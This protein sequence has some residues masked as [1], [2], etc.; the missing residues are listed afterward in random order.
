MQKTMFLPLSP[1]M[2]DESTNANNLQIIDNH[3]SKQFELH[4]D[5]PMFGTHLRLM[6]GDLKTVNR[7][8]SIKIMRAL[9]SAHPYDSLNWIMVGLGLWHLRLNL[10]RLIHKIHWEGS[11][12]GDL[13]SLQY[14]ADRWGRSNLSQATTADFRALEDL[15]THS[16]YARITALLHKTMGKMSTVNMKDQK[17]HLEWIASHTKPMWREQLEKIHEAIHEGSTPE[18]DDHPD[19]HWL[20][21]KRFCQHVETYLLLAYA[22]KRADIG[23][24]RRALRECCI[25][26]QSKAGGKW[27][28]GRELI[29]LIHLVDSP[30]AHPDLQ[31]AVLVNSLTNLHT[32][33]KNENETFET[34]RLL[35]LLNNTLK[36]FRKER[37]SSTQESEELLEMCALNGPFF[38]KLKRGIEDEFGHPTSQAHPS[39]SAEEDILD[40]A[41]ELAK[42]SISKLSTKRETGNPAVDLITDGLKSLAANVDS[43]NAD[44]ALQGAFAPDSEDVEAVAWDEFMAGDLDALDSPTF[45]SGS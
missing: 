1:V 36:Q 30:A 26:F 24:L 34:D 45:L 38:Q 31:R 44:I 2:L 33:G 4:R 11:R 32:E 35:E 18:D 29:R 28:Y 21:H 6:Y 22:I 15:T 41:N 8:K 23:L 19:K 5:E 25:L 12:Q 42:S 39:K 20:N 14:A 16:Y 7:I 9:L 3:I 43:Y 13:T 17:D 37:Q 40:M 27:N 10:L